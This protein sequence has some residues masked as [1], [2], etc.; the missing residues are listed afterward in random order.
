MFM[1]LRFAEAVSCDLLAAQ[2]VLGRKL[3]ERCG[4][5]EL[6]VHHRAPAIQAMPVLSGEA[7]WA[8][9]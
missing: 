8:E 6:G 7:F 3:Q 4:G 1:R 5:Q 2:A 9:G